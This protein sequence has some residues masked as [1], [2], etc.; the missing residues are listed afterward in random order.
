MQLQMIL[1]FIVVL[2]TY[3]LRHAIFELAGIGF[4]LRSSASI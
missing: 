4:L 3:K 2:K 1:E